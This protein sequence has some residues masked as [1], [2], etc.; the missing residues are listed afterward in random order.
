M[1]QSPTYPGYVALGMN[2]V[3]PTLRT[4]YVQQW[5]MNV[6]YEVA[7]ETLVEV[8]YVGTKGVALPARVAA[9]QAILASPTN[10]VNGIA[11]NTAAN[12]PLRVP[13][14]GFSNEGLLTEETVADSR[15][16]ALQASV[17]LLQPRAAIPRFLHLV[18][19]DGRYLRAAAPPSSAKWQATRRIW[20]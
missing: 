4:P 17:T 15:Y 9:D 5:G 7:R 20:R 14:I 16:N 19:G 10:P 8:G 11:T 18:E 1:L 13:Y 12:A 6:Q 3:D 2:A